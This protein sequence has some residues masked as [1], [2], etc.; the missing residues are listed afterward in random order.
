MKS[1]RGMACVL[2]GALAAGGADVLDYRIETEGLR[3]G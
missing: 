1:S 2:S 3:L